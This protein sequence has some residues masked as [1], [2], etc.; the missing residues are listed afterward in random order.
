MSTALM[1]SISELHRRQD[2]KAKDKKHVTK[3]MPCYDG[4]YLVTDIAPEIST[5]TVEL[6]NHPN[7]FSTFHSSQV[8]PFIE[9]NEGLFLGCTLAKPLLVFVNKEEEYSMEKILDK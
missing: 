4:P 6:L 9:N 1:H 5:V 2:Y 8:H 7:M 3:F